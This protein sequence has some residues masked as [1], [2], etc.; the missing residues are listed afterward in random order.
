MSLHQVW[1]G[2]AGLPARDPPTGACEAGRLVNTEVHTTS[3]WNLSSGVPGTRLH[4]ALGRSLPDDLR[5]LAQPHPLLPG[6][7]LVPSPHPVGLPSPPPT[8]PPSHPQRKWA[9]V[10]WT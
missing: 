1:L 10:F 4:L 2:G 7:G 5:A 9:C 3:A 6:L 8:P